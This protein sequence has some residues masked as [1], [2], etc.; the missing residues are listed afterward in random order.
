[1]INNFI[2]VY[3]GSFDP[4]SLGH[5]DII[6]RSLSFCKHLIIAIGINSNKKSLFS[7]EEKKDL[8]NNALIEYFDDS[9]LKYLSWMDHISV[10]SFDGLLVNFAEERKASILI[11]G[12][13]SVS[14]F[15]YEINIANT[16][17][18]LN[19]DIET[20]FL[21]TS[22]QLMVVSSSTVKEIAKYQGDISKFVPRCVA[23]AVN[24]KFKKI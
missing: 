10:E 11:R 3:A 14:D 13:R 20:V 16:N 8:I 22:P 18:M 24:D 7:F 4:I 19:S 23:S 21:P 12:I 6:K 9:N 2:A 17:K 5:L 15:E 1:M